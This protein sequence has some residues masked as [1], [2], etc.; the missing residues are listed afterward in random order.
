MHILTLSAPVTIRTHRTPQILEPG[1]YLV[2]DRNAWEIAFMAEPGMVEINRWGPRLVEGALIASG[3]DWSGKSI[4]LIR[5]G[6]LG[7]L[8]LLGCVVREIKRR[9]PTC[10]VALSCSPGGEEVFEGVTEGKPDAFVPYPLPMSLLA[11][12]DAVIPMEGATEYSPGAHDAHMV[13]VF[14]NRVGIEMPAD[15][16]ARVPAFA[17]SDEERREALR[18]YPR[19]AR[20]RLALQ[21]GGSCGVRTYPADL[22]LQVVYF[23]VEKRGWEVMLLG[24]P[25]ELDFGERVR[26]PGRVK[27]C[28]MDGLSFRESAGVVA[29]SD[30]VLAPDSVWTHVAGA[31]DMPAVALYGSESWLQRTA[32]Y[33]KTAALTSGKCPLAPCH[34]WPKNMM[35]F[36]A[37]GPC[38]RTGCCVEMAWIG[39]ESKVKAGEPGP[40]RICAAVERCRP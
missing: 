18:R 38:A 16:A 27:N 4:L 17:T 14:A 29:T 36:P 9:W 1:S 2:E 31:L 19:T 23:L 21:F 22:M 25:G 39:G 11:G 35:D 24:N 33:P 40:G 28:S 34:H 32:Q 15:M 7:A 3:G 5:P 37:N 10:A 8:M 6:G 12:Y 13:D 30:V 20:P 26:F